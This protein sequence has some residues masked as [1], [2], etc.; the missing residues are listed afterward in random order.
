MGKGGRLCEKRRVGECDEKAVGG[1][2]RGGWG[3]RNSVVGG[4]DGLEG[5]MRGEGEAQI[6]PWKTK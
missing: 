5:H 6:V 4:G 1:W 2:R 3:M